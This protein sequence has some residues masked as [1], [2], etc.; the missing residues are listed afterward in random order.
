MTTEIIP[1][2]PA[3]SGQPPLDGALLQLIRPSASRLAS[4]EGTSVRMLHEDIEG[5]V[6]HLPGNGRPFC[7]R[8]IRTVLWA[9]LSDQPPNAVV[10]GLY[11]L[12][13][14]NQAEG[15]AASEY[16]SVAHAMVRIVREISGQ[17]WTTTQGSAWIQFYMW[18][19]PYVI[20]AAQQVASQQEAARRAQAAQQEAA[21]RRAFDQVARRS[22]SQR[23][24]DVDVTAVAGMLDDEDDDDDGPGYGQIM[25]GM[26]L[27]PRRDD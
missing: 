8:M 20:A 17:S 14:T 5:L 19:Q 23:A 26:T 1:D 11:W 12:G 16:V 18:M 13:S 6:R 25:L 21:R 3:D 22:P 15:F 9:V 2:S 7:E 4:A 27:N 24:A 10:D